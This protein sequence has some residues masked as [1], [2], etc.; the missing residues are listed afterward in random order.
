MVDLLLVL[1]ILAVAIVAAC[2]TGRERHEINMRR[3]FDE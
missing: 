2:H 3:F 1:S